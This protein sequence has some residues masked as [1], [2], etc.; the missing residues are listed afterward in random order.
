MPDTK[1]PQYSQPLHSKRACGN[2]NDY[3]RVLP[4]AIA[5]DSQTDLDVAARR[6]AASQ[7][8]L[9]RQTG[10]T[11]GYGSYA[12]KESGGGGRYAYSEINVR[13]RSRTAKAKR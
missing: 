13:Q 7:L 3:A 9:C 1:I 12:S 11:T 8:R 4:S 6:N 5:S 2:G 10:G